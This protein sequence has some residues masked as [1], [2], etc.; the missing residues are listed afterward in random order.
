MSSGPAYG[1]AGERATWVW[2]GRW[3]ERDGGEIEGLRLARRA[4]DGHIVGVLGGDVMTFDRV[5]GNERLRVPLPAD[6]ARRIEE[7]ELDRLERLAAGEDDTGIDS[8]DDLV[9]VVT[10]RW[11]D[12]GGPADDPT[13]LLCEAP[14]HGGDGA[15]CTVF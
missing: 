1:S 15:D 8:V 12:A 3:Q 6:L 9:D 11:L 7:G 10:T 14:A 2:E 13:G 4:S 5:G